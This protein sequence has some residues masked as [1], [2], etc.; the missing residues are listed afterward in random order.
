MPDKIRWGI[1]STANIGRR[2]LVPAL[3]NASNGALVAV[4]SRDPGKAHAF[5]DELQIP[6]AYGSYDDLLADPEIDAIYNP[7]PN[8]QHAYWSIRAAAAGKHVLCEKPLASDAAE[9][10]EMVKA[11]KAHGVLLA[12]AFMYRFHPRTRRVREL[13]QSGAV[14]HVQQIGSAFTFRLRTEENIR[15]EGK[16]AGG[17]IMDI[18]CYAVGVMRF[19]TGEE[20]VAVNAFAHYND[21]GADEMAVGTLVFPSGVLGHFDCGMRAQ[22]GQWYDIRGS[23]GRIFIEDAFVAP[24]DKVTKI[25][26]WHGDQHEEIEFAP[27]DQYQLMAE[28][29]ADAILNNRPPLYPPEDGVEAMRLMDRLRESAQANRALMPPQPKA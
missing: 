15:L 25:R 14:G 2:A 12:E 4:A 8:D 7:L 20:P 21:R 26:Y 5:A 6:R 24:K 11:F 22:G 1:L 23:E 29:F 9:A 27:V 13:V 18:G 19:V 16:L 17:A 3:H 10:Q 28:D